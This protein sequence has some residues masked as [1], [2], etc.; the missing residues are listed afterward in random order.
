MQL[1]KNAERSSGVFENFKVYKWKLWLCF[2]YYKYQTRGNKNG[3]WVYDKKYYYAGCV[4]LCNT[5]FLLGGAGKKKDFFFSYTG[6]YHPQRTAGIYSILIF[7]V[8]YLAVYGIVHFTPIA[9]LTQPSAGA[10]AGLGISAV[11]PALLVSFIQQAFAEEMLFRGFIGKRLISKIGLPSGN[12]LQAI[13]FGFMHV[14]FSVSD[15]RNFLSYLIILISTASGGWLL[16][17]MDE[18]LCKGSLIPSILLHGLGNF[19]MVLSEAF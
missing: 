5:L 9:A 14:L 19:I 18:K 1:S 17:Y 6:L 7:A 15:E 13:I 4:F 2:S 3:L 12:S 11:I 10:Y 8:M 16:G